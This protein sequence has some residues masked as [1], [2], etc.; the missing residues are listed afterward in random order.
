MCAD[1]EQFKDVHHGHVITGNLKI[2]GYNDIKKLLLLNFRIKQPHNKP[3]YFSSIHLAL[4][5]FINISTSSKIPVKMY[6]V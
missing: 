1:Y 3:K 4:D 5:K 2:I 6:L